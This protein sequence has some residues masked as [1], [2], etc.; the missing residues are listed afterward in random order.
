[1]KKLLLGSAL[2][3]STACGV[4]RADAFRQAVPRAKDVALSVPSKAGQPLTGPG[5]RRDGLEGERAYFYAVTRAVTLVVNG[6]TAAVL[7]LVENITRYPATTVGEDSAVWGPHTDPLSPNTW[8]LTVTRTAPDTY[9]YVLEGKGKTEGDSAYRVVLS[10]SHQ[11]TGAHLGQGTFLLDFD[12]AQELPEHGKDVGAVAVTYARPSLTSTV[13]VDAAFTQVLDEETGQR[14][15][16]AYRFWQTPGQGGRFEFA[17]H[18]DM[19]IGA[20]LERLSVTSRWL[21]SGAGRSDVSLSGGELATPATAN[22]CWDADFLSRWA[23]ATFD[24]KL[25]WGAASSCAF[26]AAEY[27]SL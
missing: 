25:N 18:K 14:T 1:M 16:A 23:A 20:A 5:T 3:L 2:L 21:E 19:V 12:R 10:G 8:K 6:A 4:D 13:Q 15:D 17:Q 27:T 11:A 24:P 7:N 9:S 22:E 26:T